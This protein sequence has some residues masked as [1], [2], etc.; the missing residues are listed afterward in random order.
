MYFYLTSVTIHSS[1]R[2]ILFVMIAHNSCSPSALDGLVR[3]LASLPSVPLSH[4]QVN[5]DMKFT[6]LF[7]C[8]FLDVLMEM[9][10]G[11]AY[12]HLY[13]Y[14]ILVAFTRQLFS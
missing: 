3:R 2:S 1:L 8:V 13:L 4:L 14:N 10:S 11:V 5:G 9:R 6:A 12:F 7:F